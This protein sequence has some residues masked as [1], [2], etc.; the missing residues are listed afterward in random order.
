MKIGLYFGSF[1]PIH[2]GHLIIAQHML[3]TGLFDTIRFVVSPQNPFKKQEGL[4]DEKMRFE[5]V[6]TSIL[7]NSNFEASDIEFQL[8]KP[9]Y[10][11][12]TLQKLKSD[13]PENIF[14]IIMGSDQMKGLHEWKEIDSIKNMV[15][16]HVYQR[17]GSEKH[18]PSIKGN[19][20]FHEGPFLDI[21]ATYIRELIEQ[22]KS[23]Q[24]LVP[25]NVFD[26]FYSK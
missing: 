20:H 15:D 1:N 8:P 10:T 4:M 5:M 21:S 11:I 18:E 9:S 3:N 17:R 19:F 6:K 24:Y 13:E 14:S 16:F 2:N 23:I 25:E 7:D 22:K 12:Q 26:H